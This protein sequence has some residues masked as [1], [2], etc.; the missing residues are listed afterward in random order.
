MKRKYCLE[1]KDKYSEKSW[2]F[3]GQIEYEKIVEFFW[4][5][6]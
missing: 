4:W 1:I 2:E 5:N 3:Q 6:N